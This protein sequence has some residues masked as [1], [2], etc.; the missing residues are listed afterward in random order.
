M[1][2]LLDTSAV[3]AHYRRE[4]GSDIVQQL[5][6]SDEALLSIAS[7]TLTE[8]GRRLRDLG[9][10]EDEVDAILDSYQL[11]LTDVA[12]IDGDVAKTAFIIGCRTSPR[13]PL[14]DALISA[15]AKMKGAVLVHRDEHMRNI[16]REMVSQLDLATPVP[17]EI[18]TNPQSSTDS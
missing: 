17:E 6:E 10:A 7:I 2:Y 9:A 18:T 12:V 16:P 15:A 13:L 11:I 5:F 1:R 8:F 3:L 14:A 4:T